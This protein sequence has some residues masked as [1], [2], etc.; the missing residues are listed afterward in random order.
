MSV[1]SLEHIRL[2][3]ILG[4]KH[5]ILLLRWSLVVLH[6]AKS[7]LLLLELLL[8]KLL[9][10]LWLLTHECELIWLLC[11]SHWLELLL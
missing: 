7:I 6:K 9:G 5:I 2:I 4:S 3:I 8:L 11:L 1:E 10:L